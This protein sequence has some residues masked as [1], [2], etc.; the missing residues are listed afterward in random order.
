MHVRDMFDTHPA[1]AGGDQAALLDCIEACY[2]CA[3]ACT[4]CADACLAEEKAA[5]LR[6]CIRLN[7]DCADLCAATGAIVSRQ[8]APDARLCRAAIE[9]CLAACRACAAECQKHA[10][11][12]EHCR[13]C[14]RACERCADA[15]QKAMNA[16][17]LAGPNR[18]APNMEEPVGGGFWRSRAGAAFLVAAAVAAFF[19]ATEH[20]AHLL[21][22]L[23]YL[24]LLACPLIHLFMHRGHGG[25]GHGGDGAGRTS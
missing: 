18:G 13:V 8:T 2:A 14:A 6:R 7:L 5:E 21:G 12:H 23:P 15:C 24:I 19:L 22:A 9:A 20:E 1:K 11:M 25:H 3:Q 10:G 16:A 4:A 17:M